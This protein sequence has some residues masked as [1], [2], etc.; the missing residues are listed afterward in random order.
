MERL[1][2]PPKRR[3]RVQKLSGTKR[4]TGRGTIR[5]RSVIHE[6]LSSARPLNGKHEIKPSTRARDTAHRRDSGDTVIKGRLRVS[7][8]DTMHGATALSNIGALLRGRGAGE[9]KR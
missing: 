7:K 5:A 2:R 1:S 8:G 6:A 3:R 9:G 4:V